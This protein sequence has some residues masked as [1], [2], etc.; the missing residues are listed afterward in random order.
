MPSTM[1]PSTS[2]LPARPRDTDLRL[3][4]IQRE[5]LLSAR[6]DVV[7]VRSG[8]LF[9]RSTRAEAL[10]Q[11]AAATALQPSSGG[12]KRVSFAADNES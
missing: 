5:E 11:N 3:L 6:S 8:A 9:F 12:K 4:Q 1:M 7:Y 10:A 2:Q